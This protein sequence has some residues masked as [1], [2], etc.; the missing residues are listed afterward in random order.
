M[1]IGRSSKETLRV[2]L[3]PHLQCLQTCHSC[4]FTGWR[5]IHT[6]RTVETNYV[7]TANESLQLLKQLSSCATV[8]DLCWLTTDRWWVYKWWMVNGVTVMFVR[9]CMMLLLLYWHW[10]LQHIQYWD[11]YAIFILKTM[12]YYSKNNCLVTLSSLFLHYIR[13]HNLHLNIISLWCW[14]GKITR[15]SNYYWTECDIVMEG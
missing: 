2:N 9:D 13:R 8:E 12:H 5:V 1:I 3:S 15:N 4:G 7:F 14:R 10:N 6:V 11:Q